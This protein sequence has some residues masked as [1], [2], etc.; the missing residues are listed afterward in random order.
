MSSTL[1][2]S[3]EAERV[4]RALPGKRGQSLRESLLQRLQEVAQLSALR[5]FGD[6]VTGEPFYLRVGSLEARYTVDRW[7]GTV[8][9][10]EVVRMPSNRM[11]SVG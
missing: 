2:V 9:L 8:T 10:H 11:P 7:A 6:E 4:L 1:L 3:P 5:R